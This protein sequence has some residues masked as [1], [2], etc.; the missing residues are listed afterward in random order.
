MRYTYAR[1]VDALG[2]AAQG[3]AAE[4][5]AALRGCDAQ[6]V[7][8]HAARHKVA[9]MLLAALAEH[10]VHEG[11]LQP[12]RALLQQYAGH[13]LAGAAPLE[14]Q[15]EAVASLF[16]KAQIAHVF[17]KTAGRLYAGDARARWT[18]VADIDV[19][20]SRADAERAAAV[21]LQNGYG[22]S[23]DEATAQGYKANHHHLAPFDAPG[24]GK[25]LELHVGL[26]LPGT[27]RIASDFDTLAPYFERPRA[28]RPY[29]FVLNGAGRAIH[30]MIHGVGLYRLSDAVLIA[31]E[32]RAQPDLLRDLAA[33]ARTDPLQRIGML[34]VLYLAARIA[35]QPAVLD[36]D[37]QRY[38]EWTIWREDLAERYRTRAQLV[39]AWFAGGGRFVRP[40][41]AN[42][43]PP[44]RAYNGEPTPL[45]ARS[46]AIA[47]LVLAGFVAGSRYGMY[48]YAARR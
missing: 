48:G 12:L 46:K 19:L 44:Q 18:P 20:V 14:A 3:N 15:I 9:P 2:T 38:A 8:K 11:A 23:T 33:L 26:A 10:R 31:A 35:G 47:G 7:F 4:L 28:E 13:A 25:T 43:L 16:E 24:G 22:C 6:I 39:D 37:A 34:A 17:L 41:L 45:F 32:L 1:L 42:A 30:A 40:A 5:A 29:S 36:R 21:L 27:F